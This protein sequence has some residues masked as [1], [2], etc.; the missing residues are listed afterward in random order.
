M[1]N[2][3]RFVTN[4][5]VE[6]AETQEKKKFS[7]RMVYVKKKSFDEKFAIWTQTETPN[8][9]RFLI[10]MYDYFVAHRPRCSRFVGGNFSSFFSFFVYAKPPN[11]LLGKECE[12]L[13]RVIQNVYL[14]YSVVVWYSRFFFFCSCM[15]IVLFWLLRLLYIVF[16]SFC[17]GFS[18]TFFLF[19]V[20]CYCCYPV[21]KISDSKG[22]KN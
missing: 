19:C 7:H 16:R 2:N 1:K 8:C 5:H 22:E 18:L 4:T 6:T 10:L 15:S 14:F 11:L 12:S 9:F 21:F 17:Y 3:T 20:C 13:V